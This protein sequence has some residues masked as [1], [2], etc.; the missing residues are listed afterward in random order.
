MRKIETQEEVEKKQK[1]NKIVIGFVLIFLMVFSTAGFALIGNDSGSNSQG[2]GQNSQESYYNGQYWVYNIEGQ[3]YYFTNSKELT[4]NQNISVNII[5]TSTNFIGSSLFIDS[6]SDI[7]TN[8]ISINLGKFAARIQKACYGKCDE[9]LPEKD[10][11]EN[12][13]VYKSSE[14][15]K[16]YQQGN[17]IFIDGDLTTV[18]AFL[19]KLLEVN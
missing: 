8:E 14:E 3:E 7:I 6:K 5:T 1:R 10:C 4:Q 15:K 9:D 17:C 16:V 13:I 12:L 18:D 11:T 2:N 19:Y